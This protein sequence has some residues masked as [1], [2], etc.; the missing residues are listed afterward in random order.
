M[1]KQKTKNNIDDTKSKSY[2]KT[3]KNFHT[4]NEL[5]TSIDCR[6]STKKRKLKD[7]KSKTNSN[8]V[9]NTLENDNEFTY[10]RNKKNSL[11]LEN[12]NEKY[13]NTLLKNKSEY[14]PNLTE[15]KLEGF[16]KQNSEL[17]FA[18]DI[19]NKDTGIED[20]DSDFNT[21]NKKK[22]RSQGK[23]NK[24]KKAKNILYYDPLNPYLTNWAN[25]FLKIGYN[26]GLHS[27]ENL[28]GV[29]IL[30][31]QKLKPKVVL[32]PI[33]KVKYNQFSETKNN[34][35]NDD[36]VSSIV[37]TKVA[38]KLFNAP[39]TNYNNLQRNKSKNSFVTQ[40]NIKDNEKNDFKSTQIDNN[41]L[42]ISGK[43]NEGLKIEKE[44]DINK[45]N[46]KIEIENNNDKNDV[47]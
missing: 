15:D 30:R 12:D 46:G 35:N 45:E 25:S 16:R 34:V 33:Y 24:R 41:K 5:K 42:E 23:Y 3:L 9:F 31:I 2:Q 38:Q 10:R 29:P 40:L 20:N 27:N 19:K 21:K 28:D 26:V 13:G 17:A 7:I 37:C 8:I 11:T 39:N 6:P 18:D 32:P 14:H 47:K 1:I 22:F 44:E 4:H 36:S 43:L